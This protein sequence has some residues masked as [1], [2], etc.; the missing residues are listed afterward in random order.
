ML[1]NIYGDSCSPLFATVMLWAQLFK[2]GHDSLEE[3]LY[4]GQLIDAAT[5]EI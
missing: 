1:A 5:K 4:S 2:A 3:D